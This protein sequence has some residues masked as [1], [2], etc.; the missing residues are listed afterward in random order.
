[1][2]FKRIRKFS[3]IVIALAMSLS[4]FATSYAQDLLVANNKVHWAQEKMQKWYDLGVIKGD[5]NGDL[6]YDA[7]I[8][9]AEVV[10]IVNNVFGFQSK[11]SQQFNDV[12]EIHGMLMN[13]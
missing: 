12:K 6:M 1:M 10:T 13:C 8:S 2:L 4:A 7:Y 11:A 9:R 5:E 3:A